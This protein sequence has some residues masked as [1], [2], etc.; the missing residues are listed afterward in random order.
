VDWKPSGIRE[1][2]KV[3]PYLWM[4]GSGRLEAGFEAGFEAVFEG[5]FE[6]SLDGCFEAGLGI[7]NDFIEILEGFVD[8]TVAMI[9]SEVTEDGGLLGFSLFSRRES[10]TEPSESLFSNC[11]TRFFRFSVFSKFSDFS[12]FPDF[13]PLSHFSSSVFPFFL[14]F[15]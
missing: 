13:S 2:M 3:V 11:I 1:F 6:A 4:S 5:G 9:F 10:S 12:E 14:I 8:F 7:F 15:P